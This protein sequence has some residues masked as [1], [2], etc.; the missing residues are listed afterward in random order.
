MLLRSAAFDYLG[1]EKFCSRGEQLRA[2]GASSR[3]Q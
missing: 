1:F 2:L 3:R